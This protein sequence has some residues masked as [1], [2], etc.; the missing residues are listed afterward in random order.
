MERPP[1][2]QPHRSGTEN[3]NSYQYQES[4]I[5]YGF[6]EPNYRLLAFRRGIGLKYTLHFRLHNLYYT[7]EK[8]FHK[9]LVRHSLKT[10]LKQVR[11]AHYRLGLIGFEIGFDWV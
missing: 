5:G 4:L 1:S 8:I 3:Q 9:K 2:S 7:P 11:Q 10:G 6:G